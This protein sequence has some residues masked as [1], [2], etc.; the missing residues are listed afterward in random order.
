MIED[1]EDE[2]P[3]KKHKKSDVRYKI[4]RIANFQ[5]TCCSA[6]SRSGSEAITS[7]R[8]RCIHNTGKCTDFERQ[9]LVVA[10]GVRKQWKKE[11]TKRDLHTSDEQTTYLR[12]LLLEL[13]MPEGDDSLDTAREIGQRRLMAKEAADLGASDAG[14]ADTGGRPSRKSKTAANKRYVSSDYATFY[15]A[16]VLPTAHERSCKVKKS[17]KCH[18]RMTTMKI[19][20][21]KERKLID[22]LVAIPTSSSLH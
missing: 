18:L 6:A 8:P 20:V 21:R 19:A 4:H 16:D 2:G 12:N 10:C 3:A 1:S 22:A 14:P 13:G 15:Q 5:L 11:Y 9:S 7:M 17:E